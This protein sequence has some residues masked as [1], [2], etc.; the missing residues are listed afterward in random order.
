MI[1]V[2]DGS[3]Q[4]F[5]EH[6]LNELLKQENANVL[7]YDGN[8]KDFNINS[9]IDDC[10]SNNLF[11]N[12][13]II[14]VKDAPFLCKKVDEDRLNCLYEYI[15]NPSVDTDL[16]FYTFDNK[17]NS[18]L[19]TYKD[20]LKNARAFSFDSLDYRNFDNFVNQEINKNKLDIT[21]EAITRLNTICKRDATLLI[22]NIEV[23]QNYPDKINV[24]VIDK[25]CTASDDNDAF[26]MINCLT[27]KQISK[28][29]ELER[30]LLNENDSVMSVIGLLSSQL[31]FLYQ[32]AYYR[33]IGKSK[34]DI[35]QI[36]K[37][38][39]YRYNKSLETLN[40]IT[41]NQIIELLNNLSKLD[42]E[43]KTSVA[44]DDKQ[45]FELYILNL[46]KKGQHASD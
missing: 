11:A 44:L 13:N 16:I 9:L 39:E 38:S 8:S 32:I 23:L 19:K 14:L 45:R 43:C 42:I 2:I 6:K 10:V 21:K 24:E 17:H 36:T 5:I 25:L 20:V 1:Y 4:V 37:C 33:S 35:L 7:K 3:E 12:K 27:K 34:T 29:I 31:R 40:R 18:K 26:D 22:Q 46:L 15:N 41:I 30:K 28:T